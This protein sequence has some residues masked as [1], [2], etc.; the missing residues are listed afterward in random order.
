MQGIKVG[1]LAE[2][3]KRSYKLSIPSFG[4]PYYENVGYSYLTGVSKGEHC[5]HL[6]IPL[7]FSQ[8]Q[9]G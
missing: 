1:N 5:Y 3:S 4:I 8:E 9:S 2:D 6:K 7:E